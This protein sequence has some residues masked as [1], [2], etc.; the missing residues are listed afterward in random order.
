MP[1]WTKT[2]E[3]REYPDMLFLG[4]VRVPNSTVTESQSGT[5]YQMISINAGPAEGQSGLSS[6]TRLM[7]QSDWLSADFDPDVFNLDVVKVAEARS[8]RK[9]GGT[10]DEDQQELVRMAG[11]K[12]VFERNFY[13]ANGRSL[14]QQLLGEAF[15]EF[16][17][18]VDGMNPTE[19]GEAFKTAFDA[20]SAD[21]LFVVQIRQSTDREGAPT[22]RFDIEGLTRIESEEDIENFKKYRPKKAELMFDIDEIG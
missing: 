3:A 16:A 15:D 1:N 7:F 8:I 4:N 6:S 14:L 12:F 22:D 18:S 19:F 13:S 20:S 10:L 17:A 9:A 11:Q 5:G 21:T 2:V